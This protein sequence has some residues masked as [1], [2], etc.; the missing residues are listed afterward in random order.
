MSFWVREIAGWLLILLGLGL[1]YLCVAILLG[2]TPG[3][4][5]EAG[6]LMVIGIFVFRGGIHLLKVSIAARVA[7]QS[8]K[9]T[10]RREKE[11]GT[12]LRGLTERRRV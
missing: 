4:V 12:P 11:A 8:Q 10:E 7:M 9:Q 2:T 6:P 1:F 3:K 5:L